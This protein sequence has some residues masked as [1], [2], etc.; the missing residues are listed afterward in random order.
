MKQKVY[1]IMTQVWVSNIPKINFLI[2]SPKLSFEIKY[3]NYFDQQPFC[4]FVSISKKQK[5]KYKTK[6]KLAIPKLF[7]VTSRNFQ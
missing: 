2:N 3:G 7:N 1:L 6:F 4:F 5:Q